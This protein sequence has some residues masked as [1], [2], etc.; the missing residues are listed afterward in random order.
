MTIDIEPY[1]GAPFGGAKLALYLGDLLAV[2]LRD[3]TPG[4][5]FAD[6]WDFPGGGRENGETPQD[7]ALRECQ[8]ELGLS[9]PAAAIVWGRSFL[10]GEQVKWFF[11]AQ[12]PKA[13]IADVSFGDE[14]QEW[15]MMGEDVFLRHPRAV[16]AFQDRLALWMS[17]R[18]AERKSVGAYT[19]SPPL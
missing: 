8:E 13:T 3:A 14:G 12:M 1:D 15:R 10:E 19:K 16:P 2:I 5:I 9:V 4:L 17:E 7:C 6:H 18:D 11:V